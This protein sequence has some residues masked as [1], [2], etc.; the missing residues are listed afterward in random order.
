MN[1]MVLL[2]IG[3]VF[4]VIWFVILNVMVWFVLKVK[5]YVLGFVF[6]LEIG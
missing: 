1:G 4:C 5:L 2:I 3:C 6:D